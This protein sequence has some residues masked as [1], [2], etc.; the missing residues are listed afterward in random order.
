MK[1]RLERVYKAAQSCTKQAALHITS[2]MHTAPMDSLDAH[3]DLLP[4]QLLIEKLIHRAT[5]R[6]VTLPPSHPL[7]KHVSRVTKRYVKRH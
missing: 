7:A 1:S 6:L 3:T 5:A 2:A 4:F